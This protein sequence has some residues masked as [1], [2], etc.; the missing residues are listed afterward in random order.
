VEA[1]FARLDAALAA[2]RHAGALGPGGQP[3]GLAR[4]AATVRGALE[5]AAAG[6]EARRV[7]R[8][9]P[10]LSARWDAEGE[11]EVAEAAS[12]TS[13]TDKIA[14][15][16]AQLATLRATVD[17]LEGRLARAPPPA[18]AARPARRPLEPR[19]A[20]PPAPAPS[21]PT[22]RYAPRGKAPPAAWDVPQR[23]LPRRPARLER[24]LSGE[25]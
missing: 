18:A 8:E 20:N 23:A 15:L 9:G 5:A 17:C 4:R 12:P 3:A 2:A 7:A 6:A 1:A 24:A 19:R 21:R 16:A 22:P 10:T 25:Q 13:P 11:E 14:A